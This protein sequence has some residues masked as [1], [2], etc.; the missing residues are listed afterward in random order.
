[1]DK[2]SDRIYALV[3]SVPPGRV[4][5]YGRVA[6]ALGNRGLARAVGTAMSR[7]GDGFVTPCWRVVD[8][9]GRL[10]ASFGV[11][12]PALQRSL[13]EAEGVSV[14]PEGFIDLDTYGY[15]FPDPEKSAE[16]PGS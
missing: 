15:F 6:A 9:R 8:H 4:T 2:L 13:L 16:D 7:C 14:S 10:A 5:T 3:R 1:M 12:G 11:G